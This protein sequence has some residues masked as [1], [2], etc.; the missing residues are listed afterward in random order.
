MNGTFAAIYDYRMYR[1]SR[2]ELLITF[3]LTIDKN[4][5]KAVNLFK[6]YAFVFYL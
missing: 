4:I 1:I 3:L 5:K 2:T 6:H